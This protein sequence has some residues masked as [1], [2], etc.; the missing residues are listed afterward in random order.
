M[1]SLSFSFL[2]DAPVATEMII[3]AP[4]SEKNNFESGPDVM[5]S[6]KFF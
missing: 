3:P 2:Q 1:F 5:Y 6:Y 4:R